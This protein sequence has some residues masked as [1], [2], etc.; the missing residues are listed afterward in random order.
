MN[1]RDLTLG[2]VGA[3]ALGEALGRRGSRAAQQP[4]LT[5]PHPWPEDDTIVFRATAPNPDYDPEKKGWVEPTR[6]VA[7]LLLSLDKKGEYSVG[8]ASTLPEYRRQ[9]L[10]RKLYDMAW[11]YAQSQGRGLRSGQ[12]QSPLMAQYWESM[13]AAGKAESYRDTYNVTGKGWRRTR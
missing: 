7:Y 1:G 10:I 2:L 8:Q 12:V 5:G 4:Q 13:V 6:S 9:G 3:L 11:R